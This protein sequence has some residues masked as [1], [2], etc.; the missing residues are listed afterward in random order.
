MLRNIHFQRKP[1]LHHENILKDK[2]LVGYLTIGSWL[3]F[4]HRVLVHA[5]GCLA[6]R[7]GESCMLVTLANCLAEIE[8]HWWLFHIHN[9][10][11]YF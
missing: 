10:N 11:T 6:R 9:S 2:V 4:V 8:G 1:L 3:A 7:K 5:G